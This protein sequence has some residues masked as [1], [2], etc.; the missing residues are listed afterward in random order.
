VVEYFEPQPAKRKPLN[1]KQFSQMGLFAPPKP[2]EEHRWPSGYTPERKAEVQQ[3]IAGSK[4]TVDPQ[5]KYRYSSNVEGAGPQPFKERRD[6]M[7]A[8]S[9]G[10]RSPLSQPRMARAR[11]EHARGVVTDVLAR[12]T[13]PLEQLGEIPNISVSARAKSGGWYSHPGRKG[14]KRGQINITPAPRAHTEHAIM[15]ELGHHADYLANPT[16]FISRTY[17]NPNPALEGAA[18]GFAAGHHRLHPKAAE[19]P[20]SRMASYKY[21]HGNA[22]FEEH[23]Q[24]VSGKTL[25]EAM[26]TPKPEHLGQQFDPQAPSQQHLFGRAADVTVTGTQREHGQWGYFHYPE[27]KEASLGTI[28]VGRGAPSE[29]EMLP[30]FRKGDE[31]VVRDLQRGAFWGHE[32]ATRQRVARAWNARNPKEPIRHRTNY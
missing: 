10:G 5:F 22:V 27:G 8:R 9:R 28:K 13:A 21:M 26:E 14:E 1:G 7:A 2:S 12:S 30:G 31:E 3:R 6:I 4:V 20:Y 11:G 32:S 29:P 15:H 16:E 23:F 17:R 18:E 25:G 19:I 24:R